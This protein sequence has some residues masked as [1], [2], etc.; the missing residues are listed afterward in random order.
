MSFKKV[1]DQ[2]AKL[3][4]QA[5]NKIPPLLNKPPAPP[6]S[7][8]S[9]LPPSPSLISAAAAPPLA[10]QVR[11]GASMD[12]DILT[13]ISGPVGVP[14]LRVKFEGLSPENRQFA[15]ALVGFDP[16][17]G[18]LFYEDNRNGILLGKAFYDLEHFSTTAAVYSMKKAIDAINGTWMG[19]NIS[20]E[21][22]YCINLG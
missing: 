20:T 18:D 14:L 16:Y 19:S 15:E 22:R 8:S 17:S 21:I 7:Q 2:Y 5:Q 4:F 11:I 6:L 12:E 9:R 1:K 3:Q 13:S 10:N